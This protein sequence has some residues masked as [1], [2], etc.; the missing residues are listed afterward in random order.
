MKA[1][2]LL[3]FQNGS[4]PPAGRERPRPT[5]P[6]RSLGAA[7]HS[8]SDACG[9]TQHWP[10]PSPVH[11]D[12]S[13]RALPGGRH[14]RGDRAADL[15]DMR[16]SEL[17]SKVWAAPV[18]ALTQEVGLSDTRV[19][20]ICKKHGVPLPARGHWAKLAAGKTVEARR[21]RNL[22]STTRSRCESEDRRRVATPGS[23]RVCSNGHQIWK[24][25]KRRPIPK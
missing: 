14:L 8:N 18:R 17:Y 5:Y 1:S 24:T 25:A 10:R 16:R 13:R 23:C 22:R 9:V 11:Q 12:R 20:T 4:A 19:A 6:R 15:G 21:C 2:Q 7:A 3:A